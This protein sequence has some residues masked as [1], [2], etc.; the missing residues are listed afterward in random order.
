MVD[1]RACPPRIGLIYL[2]LMAPAMPK[3]LRKGFGL[4]NCVAVDYTRLSGKKRG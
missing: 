3:S 1:R 4:D 2:D